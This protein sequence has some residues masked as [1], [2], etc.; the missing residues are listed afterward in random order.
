MPFI[1]DLHIHS[2]YSRATSKD[3]NIDNISKWARTK[4]INLMGTGDFTHPDWLRELNAKLK[5][6]EY[7]IYEHDDIYYIFTVEVSNIYFKR[8]RT[9]KIHNIIFAPSFETVHE[10]NKMLSPYGKLSSDGRPILSIECNKMVKNLSAINPDIFVVP[11]HVW[12]PHFGLFGANSGFD[13]IE[14]CFDD[15][16]EKIYALETG[17]SSD[18]K[19]N[20]RWSALDR[21]SLMSNSD[22]HS[23]SKIGR[24]ANVFDK[25]FGYKELINI[26]K[27]KDKNRF[28][29]T[30]EFYPEEGKYHWDGHR[31]CHARLSPGESR[32]LNYRCPVCGAKVTVGVMQR[33]EKLSDR[34]EGFIPENVPGFKSM[35][36]LVEIIAEAIGVGRESVSVKRAYKALLEKIGT[37]F[38]I[39]LEAPI[40]KLENNCP[41]KIAKGI[42]NVRNKNVNVLPGYDGE[43]GKVTIFN[44]SEGS[45]EKQMELF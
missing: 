41:P 42:I 44:K 15:Q 45:K 1:A 34:N 11:A 23:P 35:V 32:D 10:I 2:K 26:L 24:E 17:L 7:G 38:D 12:T 27:T 20:W 39:L 6:S 33:V 30:I 18:P 22:A 13:S 8:G 3:M 36:P 4:G 9:R 5:S 14:E 40:E 21:F 16:T 19:M 25:K 28:L 43:Y 31:K 37:E 29:Y